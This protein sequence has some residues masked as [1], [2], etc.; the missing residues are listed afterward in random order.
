MS[1]MTR[2]KVVGAVTAAFVGGLGI[3]T[4]FELPPSGFAQSARTTKVANGPRDDGGAPG[5]A[6]VAERVTPAVVSIQVEKDAPRRP[7]ASRRPTNVP[8]EIGRAHV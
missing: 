2:A 8:P 5:F 7:V 6:D 1:M 4:A 3:A